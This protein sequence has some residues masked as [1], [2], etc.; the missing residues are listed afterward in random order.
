MTTTTINN[1]TARE[2]ADDVLK[3]ARALGCTDAE[4]G[5]RSGQGLT[6]TCRNAELEALEHHRDKSLSITVYKNGAKGS[7]ATTD[8]SIESLDQT[9]SAA[10]D[11]ANQSEQDK[12]AGLLEPEFLATDI[13]DLDLH[14][15]WDIDNGALIEKTLECDA[16]AKAVDSRIE[17]VDDT[18]VNYYRGLSAYAN[19]NG[20][21]EAYKASRYGLSCVVVASADSAMQRGYWYTSARDPSA[22]QDHRS[23]G[24]VA[25]ERT[26]RKLGARKIPTDKVPV[27]FEAPI[28]GGLFGHFISGISGGSLYRK[29]SFLLDSKGKQ[30][31]PE[32]ISLE[33]QPHLLQGIGSAPYDA[34]GGQTQQRFIVET[35]V[36]QDYVLSGYSARRLGLKPTGNAG[37]VHNLMVSHGDKS[38][39]DLLR[40]MNCGL[41]VTDLMGFGVNQVT[42]D[43]SRGAS[44][45]W[46]ENGEIAYPVEEITIAGN[47]ADMFRQITDIGNDVDHRGGI[48][49][50]SVLI[51]AMTVAGA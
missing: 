11:I 16:S 44:G 43:Y 51:E 14:H 30:I 7:A 13:P 42:G 31:F 18:S 17:Q 29:A 48:Q 38:F 34:D 12:Y 47:L 21:N 37:G 24:Q 36:V 2:I 50:G 9:V 46:V 33:E 3:K 39:H 19:T 40:E 20:F 22:L 23:V 27:L 6:I 26:V 41:V 45:F 49:S 8:F 5:V 1:A 10:T 4:V 32:F 35:G 28:A 15:S 25:G